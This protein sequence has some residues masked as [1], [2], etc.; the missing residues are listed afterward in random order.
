MK[1]IRNQLSQIL[2]GQ[3]CQNDLMHDRS[4]LA[5]RLELAHQRMGRSHLVVSIGADQHQVLHIRSGR[6][7]FEQVETGCVEP[8]QIV[9]KQRQRMF[10]SG[11][12][13][14]ETPEN[15]PETALSILGWKFRDWR[16]LT[17]NQLQLRDEVDDQLSVRA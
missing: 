15:Q 7:I 12:D 4:S 3:G 5:N 9:Q 8:L 1:R 11:K 13:V 14:D 17:E 6:Q 2:L 10:R 16:L